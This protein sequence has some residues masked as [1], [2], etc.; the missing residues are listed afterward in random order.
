[1][2]LALHRRLFDVFDPHGVFDS[3]R[4]DA[5]AAQAASGAT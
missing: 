4:F 1:V 3:G 5:A 2:R